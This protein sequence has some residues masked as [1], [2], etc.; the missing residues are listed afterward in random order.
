MKKYKNEA[1]K[2]DF[3][4]E[5][6][7][8]ISRSIDAKSGDGKKT[9]ERIKGG[10]APSC[11]DGV[12]SNDN[13]KVKKYGFSRFCSAAAGIILCAALVSMCFRGNLYSLWN[14]DYYGLS[15][16]V[17]MLLEDKAWNGAVL[18]EPDAAAPGS[19]LDAAA[20]GSEPDAVFDSDKSQVNSYGLLTAAMW[21][22][23]DNWN[24]WMSLWNRQD[25]ELNGYLNR[26]LIRPVGR[27]IVKVT[28]KNQ[29]PVE[30][31]NVLLK[32]AVGKTV[33]S[34]V[35]DNKGYVYL[36]SSMTGSSVSVNKAEDASDQSFCI[37]AYIKGKIKASK[38]VSEADS[39]EPVIFE[40]DNTEGQV[41]EKKLDLMFVIDT[42]GSMGDELSYLAGELE[43]VVASVARKF[44]DGNTDNIRCSA[45][46][47]RDIGDAYTVKSNDFGSA[48]DFIADLRAETADGGGDTPEAVEQALDDAVN[49]HSWDNDSV[50]L[51]FLVLDAPPH[52]ETG[53]VKKM[54]DLYAKAALKGIRIIPVVAS[55]ADRDTELLMR[56]G[57]IAT[58]GTYLFITDDSGIGNSHL[59]P[60]VG[61]VTVEKLNELI[62]KVIYG[63][64]E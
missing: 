44:S 25:A 34:G 22:D 21:N 52:N 13:L 50:K 24:F 63:Y 39:E 60:I 9:W 20:P 48:H 3:E 29:R 8:G 10:I 53:I 37:E 23:N 19:E 45:N 40:L 51:L 46:F 27:F 61:S 64:L 49:N 16:K 28:D 57:A 58:G 56:C 62:I 1:M 32:N 42:T 11:S 30:N 12:K 43:N 38:N 17:N 2:A 6:S 41:R 5:I 55:D 47:Y 7:N 35:S 59:E 15:D 54:Q 26:W 18:E 14:E 31:V 4:K 33:W 36:F